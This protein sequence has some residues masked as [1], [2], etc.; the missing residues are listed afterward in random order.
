MNKKEIK[1]KCADCANYKEE[2]VRLCPHP[3]CIL[4]PFRTNSKISSRESLRFKNCSGC[5]GRGA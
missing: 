1:L 3:D 2:G 5:S 4:Y